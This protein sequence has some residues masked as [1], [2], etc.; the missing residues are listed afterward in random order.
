M[1]SAS[2]RKISCGLYLLKKQ[3]KTQL[4]SPRSQLARLRVNKMLMMALMQMPRVSCLKRPWSRN[5]RLS[6]S[7]RLSLS[8]KRAR[9]AKLS[10][11]AFV[12]IATPLRKSDPASRASLTLWTL[13]RERSTLLS[14][15]LTG[16][17]KS[18]R[19]ASVRSNSDKMTCLRSR[20]RRSSMKKNSSCFAK[21]RTLRR[22]TATTSLSWRTARWSSEKARSKSTRSKS[23]WSVHLRNGTQ[24]SSKCQLMVSTTPTMRHFSK[25]LWMH[26]GLRASLA[27]QTRR[28]T[29]SR[30]S[31]RPSER[32]K[33]F[34]VLRDLKS[35]SEL[36]ESDSLKK[37]YYLYIPSENP[38]KSNYAPH[39]KQNYICDDLVVLYFP[40]NKS[41]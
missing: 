21:W 39:L 15:A 34:T 27:V 35:R 2:S 30:P 3:T 18:G 20:L 31:W 29:I 16:K 22:S 10:K 37:R 17:K 25:R 28:M 33:C 12:N 40:L 32:L 1:L 14:N 8:S 38:Y 19:C 36:Q 7:N 24:L 41:K 9:T 23:S 11:A 4:R 26:L 13:T 5:V 6:T